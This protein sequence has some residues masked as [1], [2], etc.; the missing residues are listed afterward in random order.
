LLLIVD[1]VKTMYLECAHSFS[2]DYDPG[3]KG[4]A[5]CEVVFDDQSQIS[6]NI[7]LWNIYYNF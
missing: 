6:V 4:H 2:Y 1:T 5:W 7:I 3:V